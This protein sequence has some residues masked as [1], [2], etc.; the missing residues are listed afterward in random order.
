MG[1]IHISKINSLI[2]H[3]MMKFLN[4]FPLVQFKKSIKTLAASI[5]YSLKDKAVF[6]GHALRPE[7]RT[8]FR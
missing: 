4:G 8:D 7:M 3:I 6:D 2:S 1:A 5:L